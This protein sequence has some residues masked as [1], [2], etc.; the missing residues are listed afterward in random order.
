MPDVAPY[1]H[2]TIVTLEATAAGTDVLMDC[3]SLHDEVWTDRII[4]GR[5]NELDNLERLT[6]SPDEVTAACHSA[7]CDCE[8][9]L[10]VR[11]RNPLVLGNVLWLLC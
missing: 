8:G 4:A 1:D 6:E 11:A 7:A 9:F 3:A 5:T 2:L 10:P